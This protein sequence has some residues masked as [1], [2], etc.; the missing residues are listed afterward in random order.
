M[1]DE[2]LK[3]AARLLDGEKM[4]DLAAT[5]TLYRRRSEVGF[6]DPLPR[7]SFGWKIFAS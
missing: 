4:A 5:V 2:R 6:L 1:M 3:F 7:F